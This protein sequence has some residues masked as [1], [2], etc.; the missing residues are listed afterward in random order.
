LTLL[1]EAATQGKPGQPAFA[2]CAHCYGGASEKPIHTWWAPTC[3]A[4]PWRSRKF[5]NNF[6]GE[7]SDGEQLAY[8]VALYTSAAP[9]YFPLVDGYIDGGVAANNMILDGVMGVADYQ[10]RQILGGNYYRLAPFFPA[11]MLIPFDGVKRIP[12]LV[13]FAEKVDISKTVGWLKTVWHLQT[14]APQPGRSGT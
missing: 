11:D 12:K 7:D 5:F 1:C 4:Q 10:C 8:K 14:A 9:T 13:A 3:P 2:L 6:P